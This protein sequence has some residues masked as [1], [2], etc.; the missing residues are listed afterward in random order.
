MPCTLIGAGFWA[1][2]VNNLKTNIIMRI[3]ELKSPYRELAEMRMEEKKV[4]LTRI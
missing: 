2:N 4:L 1:A 3:D